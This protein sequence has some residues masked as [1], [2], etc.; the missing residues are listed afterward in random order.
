[1]HKAET[2]MA[3]RI[4]LIGMA[5]L[6]GCGPPGI[7]RTWGVRVPSEGS[8]FTRPRVHWPLAVD[9]RRAL[10]R[11]RS[12]TPSNPRYS[13]APALGLRNRAAVRQKVAATAQSAFGK[14]GKALR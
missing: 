12:N 7:C 11:A 1:A 8:I 10:L 5:S 9:G 3:W 2:R 4:G 6:W 14:T 13:T